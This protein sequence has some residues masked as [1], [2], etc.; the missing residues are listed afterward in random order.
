MKI[1]LVDESILG[2][3]LTTLLNQHTVT[4]SSHEDAL[5][6]LLL[7]EPD[8][9]LICECWEDATGKLTNVSKTTLEDIRNSA[10]KNVTVKTLGFD[11][12]AFDGTCD[13][14]IHS[15]TI[16]NILQSLEE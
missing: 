11:G 5:E 2:Q 13:I 12:M 6:N 14:P 7:E 9:V 8:A 1:L 15:F 3:V 16:E 4:L 10:D